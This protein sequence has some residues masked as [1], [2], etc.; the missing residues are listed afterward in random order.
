MGQIKEYS[1]FKCGSRWQTHIGCGMMHGVLNNVLSGFSDEVQNRIVEDTKDEEFPYFDFNYRTASCKQCGNIV[2]VPVIELLEKGKTYVGACP[3]CG[4]EAE[5]SE[6][7]SCPR[8]GSGEVQSANI[9][10]WD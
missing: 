7:P 8:C 6:T 5:R 4:S 10:Y 1:C 3:Y 9:G 2:A